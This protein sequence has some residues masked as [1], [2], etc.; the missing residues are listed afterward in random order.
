MQPGILK[1]NILGSLTPEDYPGLWEKGGKITI[2][3][4]VLLFL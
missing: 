4:P 1:E 2:R 3:G